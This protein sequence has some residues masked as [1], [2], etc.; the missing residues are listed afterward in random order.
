MA[1]AASPFSA[2]RSDESNI[3]RLSNAKP[4]AS[5][6]HCNIVLISA[7]ATWAVGL[8]A[9]IAQPHHLAIIELSPSTTRG[10]SLTISRH[11]PALSSATIANENETQNG[12]A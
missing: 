3:Q 2:A 11:R 4:S 5:F 1:G 8:W 12:T 6:L 9:N 10:R 7:P